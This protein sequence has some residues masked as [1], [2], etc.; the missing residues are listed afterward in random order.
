[1]AFAK[2]S[3][4]L[5]ACDDARP[6]VMSAP[7]PPLSRLD[8]ASAAPE[9]HKLLSHLFKALKLHVFQREYD[10]VA[11]RCA[12]EGLDYSGFLLRLAELEVSERQ[13]LLIE[14]RIRDAQFP[15]LKRLDSFDF[16]AVP[17]LDKG[18][19]LEL[20][21]CDYITRRENVI[22]TGEHGTGKTHVAVALGLAACEKG[23][24]VGFF[25]AAS[26]VRALVE[27]QNERRLSRL[28]HRL[29]TC[30]LLIIDE[31]GYV[32]LSRSGGELLFEVC[33]QRC[34][35]GATMITSNLPI[36]RWIHV[37]GCERLTGALL[38]RLTHHVHL[39][40]MRGESYR[41]KH[42]KRLPQASGGALGSP[43][44]GLHLV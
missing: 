43:P 38:D 28:Q 7:E 42:G 17:A 4:A 16:A 39:L 32:P 3:A 25:T 37:F 31:L 34:E 15:A 36:D 22:A 21:R 35:R 13:Q 24:S 8:L 2:L 14:R 19:V 6:P 12:A 26:L 11:R 44:A 40:D 10:K 29:A 1:M 30:Q 23:L 33:S 5:L 9:T 20:A 27:A 18:A 41:L